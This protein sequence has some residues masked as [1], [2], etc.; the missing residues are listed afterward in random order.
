[1]PGPSPGGTATCIRPRGV[2]TCMLW[3]PTTPI[4]IC[5]RTSEARTRRPRGVGR[6]QEAEG[7][8]ASGERTRRKATR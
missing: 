3:P 8:E 5:G 1:M 2:C 4:G 7:D 6:A